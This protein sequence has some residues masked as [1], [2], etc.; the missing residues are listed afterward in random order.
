M[1]ACVRVFVGACL[2]ARFR[3]CILACAR[4]CMCAWVCVCMRACVLA[5]AR[6][7]VCAEN[8]KLFD[9]VAYIFIRCG[10]LRDNTTIGLLPPSLQS[11]LLLGVLT[12]HTIEANVRVICRT[13]L[14]HSTS[15]RK[16]KQK[17]N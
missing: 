5:S 3:G 11:V 4:T 17:L 16:W 1:R 15:W 8:L 9:S 10:Y 13:F 6:V 7:C 12:Y 14:S 2:R